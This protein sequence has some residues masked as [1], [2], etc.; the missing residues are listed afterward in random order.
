MSAE[1]RKYDVVVYGAT[2]Y[3][4]RLCAEVLAKHPTHPNWAI[5]GRDIKRL[6]ALRSKL[7]LSD[8]IGTIE[9]NNGDIGSLKSMLKQTKAIVNVVGPFREMGAEKVV[10]M[11]T[12]VGTHYFDLS[13]ETGFNA[14]VCTYDEAAR[15]AGIVL[16]SSVGFDCLPFD[17]ATY[18]SVQHLKSQQKKGDEVGSVEVSCKIIA[19]FSSGTISSALDMMDID[20]TQMQSVRPDWL[21]PIQGINKAIQGFSP[22][23]SAPYRGYAIFT[24]FTIHNTRLVNQTHGILEKAGSP[25]R[26]GRSFVYKDGVVVGHALVAWIVTIILRVSLLLQIH[27]SP[28]RWLVRKIL[29]RNYGPPTKNIWKSG[30]MD[31]S[32]VSKNVQGNK[33]SIARIFARGQPGYSSTAQMIVEC[34]LLVVQEPAELHPLAAKGGVL[35]GA[36]LGPTRLSQRLVENAGWTIETPQAYTGKEQISLLGKS[37]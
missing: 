4:G 1:D 14:S 15:R 35:T 28:L 13:G 10:Q 20:K 32:A 37:K 27:F 23:Y 17:L 6:Q 26:Y 31:V 29:P 21:S 9:A 2:G 22:F 24:P 36:L 3:T 11:C 7:N 16:A 5:A 34:A 19:G 18:L 33:S 12:E 25:D 30:Y 8:K